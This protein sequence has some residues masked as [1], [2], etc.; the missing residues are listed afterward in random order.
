MDTLIGDGRVILNEKRHRC[1]RGRAMPGIETG[2]SEL[3]QYDRLQVAVVRLMLDQDA[4]NAAQTLTAMV[5]EDL[6]KQ[7]HERQ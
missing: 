2:G 3:T 5:L 1:A 7:L 6:R 4:M